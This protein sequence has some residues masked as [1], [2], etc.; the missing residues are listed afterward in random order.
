MP[1]ATSACEC[2][3]TPA[4]TLVAA[5][6]PRLTRPPITAVL[7]MTSAR[8]SWI[9]S[10]K[11]RSLIHTTDT[12][13]HEVLAVPAAGLEN[14][15]TVDAKLGRYILQRPGVRAH[16]LYLDPRSQVRDPI[17]NPDDRERTQEPSAVHDHRVRGSLTDLHLYNC[18]GRFLVW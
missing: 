3:N 9:C 16:R 15:M 18:E 13:D 5:T 12:H 10:G 6:R 14:G 11:I 8:C 7:T 1:A 17:L 4:P 2:H